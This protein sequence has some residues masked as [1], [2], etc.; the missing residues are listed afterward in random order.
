M[1]RKRFFHFLGV[2]VEQQYCIHTTINQAVKELAFCAIFCKKFNQGKK[3]VFL[4]ISNVLK[5]LNYLLVI[6]SSGPLISTRITPGNL[7][8]FAQ[9]IFLKSPHPT[10]HPQPPPTHTL[11]GALFLCS[12]KSYNCSY[13]STSQVILRIRL[14][15]FLACSFDSMYKWG[16][17]D[18]GLISE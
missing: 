8:G 5:K 2:T 12:T 4:L 14:L 1:T 7:R 3:C 6:A 10:P 16:T 17:M 13:H 18:T 9:P 11:Q 15:K